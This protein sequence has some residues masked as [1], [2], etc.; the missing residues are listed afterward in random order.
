[1]GLNGPTLHTSA[2]HLLLAP[3]GKPAVSMMDSS[4]G[5]FVFIQLNPKCSSLRRGVPPCRLFH[6]SSP[7]LLLGFCYG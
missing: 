4:W 2:A 7:S 1:M 5:T 3:M 6:L